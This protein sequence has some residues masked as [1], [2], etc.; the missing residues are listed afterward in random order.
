MTEVTKD[1]V[2]SLHLTLYVDG[3]ELESSLDKQPIQ[4]I[5][6]HGQVI[7]GL[8]E[9]IEGMQQ[10]EEKELHIK[11]EDAYGEFDPEGRKK[12]KK[13]EFSEEIPFEL[14]TFLE[15][16][17]EEGDI[18]SAQIIDK[19]E[20]TITVDFNHPQAGQDLVIEVNVVEVRPATETELAHGHVHQDGTH[21]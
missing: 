11:A 19:D 1:Q 8:E 16:R 10:G 2:V 21:S 18:L 13:E 12:I 4:F 7:T 6:G 15:F 3:E 9:G 17:D 20:D 14:G 5:Q